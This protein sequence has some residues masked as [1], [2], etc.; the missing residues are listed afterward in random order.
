MGWV[1]LRHEETG[2]ECQVSDEPGVVYAMEARGWARYVAPDYLNPDAPNADVVVQAADAFE[3]EP[4]LSEDEALA[5]KGAALDE[6]IDKAGL[7]K[8]GTADEKR[9]R[10]AEYEAD[11][12]TT[13]EG[14]VNG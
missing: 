4:I 14:E 6:A 1:F 11:L 3:P 7:P 13:P 8:S 9:A 5:L 2:G 10:L 12:A